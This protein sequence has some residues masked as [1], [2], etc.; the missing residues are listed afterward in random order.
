M[1]E[2]VVILSVNV[3]TDDNGCREFE[4]AGLREKYLPCL[5][6]QLPDLVFRKIHL[7]GGQKGQYTITDNC[8]IW[9]SIITIYSKIDI[10]ES[11][12]NNII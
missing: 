2:Q 4:K 5:D 3:S 10:H 7:N 9:F 6:A 8:V 1:S 11:M 12:N